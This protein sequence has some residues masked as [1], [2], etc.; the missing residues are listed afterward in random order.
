ACDVDVQYAL[1]A[2]AGGA[3]VPDVR[4]KPVPFRVRGSLPAVAEPARGEERPSR[5]TFLSAPPA[6]ASYCRQGWFGSGIGLSTT[7][8]NSWFTTDLPTRLVKSTIRV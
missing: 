8:R 7:G 5:T 3:R 2:A 6:T 1:C 4:A